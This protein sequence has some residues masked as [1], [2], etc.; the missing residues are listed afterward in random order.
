MIGPDTTGDP[1]VSDD[2]GGPPGVSRR[3]LIGATLGV[4]GAAAFVGTGFGIAQA[5]EPDRTDVD[6]SAV[7]FYGPHQAGIAT[8]AQ[9]RLA[10]A[11]FDITS[12]DPT[13]VQTMLGQWAAA[14]AQMTRGLPVGAVDITPDAPPI[15]T[16]EAVGLQPSQLTITVGFGPAFFDGRFG[17]AKYR[18]AALAD[19]PTLPGDESLEADRSGGDLCVQA[20]AND[21]TRSVPRHPQLRPPGPWHRI[22]P[23]VTTR[24]RTY[25]VDLDYPA[26]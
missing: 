22:G 9:D 13:A 12:T 6:A 4:A 17:V 18:P 1:G 2:A 24:L 23:M 5:T 16:G 8:P 25:L 19:L 10:F 15:D 3:R 20:C 14:G 21:P 7:P 26:D 11:A